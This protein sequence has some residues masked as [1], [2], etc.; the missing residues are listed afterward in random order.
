MALGLPIVLSERAGSVPDLLQQGQ[1]GWAFDPEQPTMLADI[2]SRYLEK[3]GLVESQGRRSIELVRAY[4]PEH[5]AH[6]FLD[7]V[8]A[9]RQTAAPFRP[10]LLDALFGGRACQARSHEN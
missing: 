7:A 9:A 10:M 6:A 5:A 2:C 4:T 8:D 3:P 1:N